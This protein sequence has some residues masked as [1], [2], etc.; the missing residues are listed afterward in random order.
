MNWNWTFP[1]MISCPIPS[2]RYGADSII[3]PVR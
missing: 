1:G 3:F 2:T